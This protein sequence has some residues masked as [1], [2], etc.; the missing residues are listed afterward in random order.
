MWALFFLFIS[1]S[2]N[3][4]SSDSEDDVYTTP[5]GGST[6][7]PD[8]EQIQSEEGKDNPLYHTDSDQESNPSTEVNGSR[9]DRVLPSASELRQDSSRTVPN[10]LSVRTP[11]R[12]RSSSLR[13]GE[14]EREAGG[15]LRSRSQPPETETQ[16]SL[17]ERRRREG[18]GSET[19]SPRV[20][21]HP[22]SIPIKTQIGIYISV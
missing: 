17:M 15:K 5:Q 6:D 16:T 1:F 8:E 2:G 12:T 20:S 9:N 10:T 4:T 13:E 21:P 11:D 19:N 18:G 3:G 22:C 14:G 7:Q